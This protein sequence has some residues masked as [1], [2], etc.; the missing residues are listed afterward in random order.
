MSDMIA[1]C[2]YSRTLSLSYGEDLRLYKLFH[3]SVGSYMDLLGCI[4][5]NTDNKYWGILQHVDLTTS[6]WKWKFQHIFQQ[7]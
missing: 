2:T 4:S 5:Y 1:I 7:V 3:T 6:A